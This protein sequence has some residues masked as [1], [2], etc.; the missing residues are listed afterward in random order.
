MPRELG[1]REQ[2]ILDSIKPRPVETSKIP[3][4]LTVRRDA[5]LWMINNELGDRDKVPDNC[6]ITIRVPSGGD[7]SGTDLEI[8]GDEQK[9]EVRWER[10]V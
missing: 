10:Q 8:E 5:L 7:W 6:V 4:V 2:Q 1:K 9:I 3:M